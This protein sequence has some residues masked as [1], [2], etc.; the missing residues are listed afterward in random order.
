[1]VGTK[2][3]FFATFGA[4]LKI[5]FHFLGAFQNRCENYFKNSI[6]TI[7]SSGMPYVENSPDV[8]CMNNEINHEWSKTIFPRPRVI[9][10]LLLHHQNRA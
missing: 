4:L 3:N 8:W 2:I 1:M 7:G 6:K 10:K 9:T 5:Y